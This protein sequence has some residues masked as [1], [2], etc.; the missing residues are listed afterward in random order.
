MYVLS[1]QV[2]KM[3]VTSGGAVNAGTSPPRPEI[4]NIVVEIW[5]YLRDV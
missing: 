2:D 4:G 5:C 1:V 3:T